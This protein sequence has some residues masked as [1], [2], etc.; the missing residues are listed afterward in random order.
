MLNPTKGLSRRAMLQAALLAGAAGTLAACGGGGTQG[1]TSGGQARSTGPNVTSKQV[2]Y[3]DYGGALSEANKAVYFDSFQKE[4]GAAV[5]I[6][7][8]DGARFILEAQNERNQVDLMEADGF[9]TVNLAGQGL[10]EK[11]PDWVRR[12][13]LVEPAYQDYST[14]GY[15]YSIVQG[16]KKDQFSGRSPESWADFWDL[17]KFPGTR[18]LPKTFYGVAEAALLADGVSPEELYPLD[19]ARAFRKLDEIKGEVYF[20]DFYGQGAQALQDGTVALAVLPNGRLFDLERSGQSVSTVWNEALLFSWGTPVIPVGAQ[21]KD[22]AFALVDWMA[23]PERQAE[24]GR[25]IGYGPTTEAAFALLSPQELEKLPNSP[26][27][28]DVAVSV[29]A[30]VLAEQEQEYGRSYTEW[31]A[32]A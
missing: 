16:H 28:R 4:Y 32:D 22:A 27:H 17:E 18:G 26:Q 15:A 7:P 20:Y 2:V 12:S 8:A 29:S 1:A 19:F 6:A 9:F 30:E 11:L 21:H 23:D 5:T 31:L 10:L 13:D 14:G 24:L 25:R 3:A